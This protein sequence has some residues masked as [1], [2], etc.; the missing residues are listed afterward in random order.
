MDITSVDV[1]TVAGIVTIAMI[2]SGIL[3]RKLKITDKQ[4]KQLLSAGVAVILA[5][6]VQLT[7]IGFAGMAIQ[8][9]IGAIIASVFA[10][11]MTYDSLVKP[12]IL[13]AKLSRMKKPK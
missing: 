9:L 12:A 4:V 7:G 2:V 5:V 1:T 8:Q 13:A 10:T 6:V 3:I 11:K